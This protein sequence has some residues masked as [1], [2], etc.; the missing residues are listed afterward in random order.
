M[1]FSTF[2]FSIL[3]F[4]SSSFPSLF[5]SSK[6]EKCFFWR[7]RSCCCS[8]FEMYFFSAA[9]AAYSSSTTTMSFSS[10]LRLACVCKCLPV[11]RWCCCC[12]L[13]LRCAPLA[14]VLLAAAACCFFLYYL[15]RVGHFSVRFFA[16]L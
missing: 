15:L 10:Y 12:A 6:I 14:R 2:F 11:Y 8:L 3:L 5:L 9:S 16:E 4:T 13:F 7:S 1:V